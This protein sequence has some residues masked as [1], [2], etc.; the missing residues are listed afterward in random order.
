[1]SALSSGI[2]SFTV[3]QKV[4]TTFGYGTISAI[5]RIDLIIYVALINDPSSLY[6]FHPEQVKA[7]DE[8][9][10]SNV[11]RRIS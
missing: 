3:G 10:E 6:L 5:S 4:Q 2:E 11:N 9:G 7:S 8:E 1:M